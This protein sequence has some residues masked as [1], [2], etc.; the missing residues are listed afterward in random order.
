M[1]LASSHLIGFLGEILEEPSPFIL[2]ATFR[3]SL[4][5]GCAVS[6]S[7]R[8]LCESWPLPAGG[9]SSTLL[10]ITVAEMGGR[11]PADRLL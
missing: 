8:F 11:H 3:A 5:R 9:S 4:R 2:T 10:S 6:N 1:D 7:G